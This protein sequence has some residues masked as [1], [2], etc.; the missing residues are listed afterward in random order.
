MQVAGL[1]VPTTFLCKR[2]LGVCGALP[3]CCCPKHTNC[4]PSTALKSSP[5]K[6]GRS[7]LLAVKPLGPTAAFS[8]SQIPSEREDTQYDLRG[9]RSYPTLEDEGDQAAGVGAFVT[10]QM[11]GPLRKVTVPG[12]LEGRREQ[13]SN[14]V[15]GRDPLKLSQTWME[16][17]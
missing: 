15:Q 3:R 7:A 6:K 14:A 10:G 17:P 2:G 12:G 9:A 16:G 8:A 5:S 1:L 11:K 13:S 4:P